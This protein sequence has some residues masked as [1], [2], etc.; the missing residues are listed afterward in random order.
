[1][2]HEDIK[3]QLGG[4]RAGS[5]T[6]DL[7]VKEPDDTISRC[8]QEREPIKNLRGQE[9]GIVLSGDLSSEILRSKVIL[10]ALRRLGRKLVGLLLEQRKSVCLVDSL[11]LGGGDAMADP[12]PQLGARHL[13]GGS[14]LHQVVD[15]HAADATEPALHV[16]ETDVQVLADA[17]LGHLARDVHVEQVV[18]RD[19]DVLAAHEVLVRG[20][21]V[22]VEDL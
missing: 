12:L 7:V 18:G 9:I 6:G 17:L 19:L 5:D 2:G 1:M 14:I 15:R 16:S 8:S 10:V 21:H 3:L 11:A 4:G 20:W 13:G 22:L